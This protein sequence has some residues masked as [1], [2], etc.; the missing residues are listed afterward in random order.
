MPLDQVFARDRIHGVVLGDASVGTVRAIGERGGFTPGNLIGIVIAA[1]DGGAHLPLGE[2]KL[3]IAKSRI[4]EH[5]EHDVEDIVEVAF[6][7]RPGK[8]GGVESAAGFDFGSAGFK[9]IIEF[10]AALAGG[11]A[12]APGLAIDANQP[13]LVSGFNPRAAT[14]ANGAIDEWELM[15]FL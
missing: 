13:D 14:N 2:S 11:P 5:V 12:G 3:V 6:Q 4:F 9:K 8:A 7:A 1:R 15:V 10:V